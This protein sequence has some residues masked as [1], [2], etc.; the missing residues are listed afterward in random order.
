MHGEN[1]K[2]D[3]T[4]TSKCRSKWT[5]CVLLQTTQKVDWNSVYFL[6]IISGRETG[7]LFI[8]MLPLLRIVQV[9]KTKL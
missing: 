7:K 3:V 6:K 5:D 8:D 1:M 9:L 4:S 2:L